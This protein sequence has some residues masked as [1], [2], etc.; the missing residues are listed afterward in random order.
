MQKAQIKAGTEYALRE[1]HQPGA[2]LQRV[3]II[4]HMRRNKWKVTWIDPNPGLTDYV[5]SSQLVALWKEHKAFL[6]EEAS[7]RALHDH[8]KTIGYEKNGPVDGA[9]QDIFDNVGDEINWHHG[10]LHGPTDALHRLMTRAGVAITEATIP[11]YVDRQ[12]RLHLPF[13]QALTIAQAFAA[14][15]PNT[16]LVP[17]DRLEQ[18]WTRDARNPGE[19][20][21]IGL[22]NQARASWSLIR[23]WAGHDAAIAEREAYIQQLERMVWDAIYALQKAGIDQAAAKLRRALERR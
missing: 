8:N 20:H 3:R 14:A 17:I 1:L 13:D 6:K 16:V 15:E 21:L 9:L 11:A 2:Q 7:E 23:Q 18:E 12:G 22:L 10:V 4:E 5:E 19:N